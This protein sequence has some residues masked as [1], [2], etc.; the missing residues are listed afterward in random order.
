VL[1]LGDHPARAA[2]AVERAPREVG[3]AADGTALSQTRQRHRGEIVGDGA[4]QALVARQAEDVIDAVRLAPGH[5]LVAGKAR[6]GTQQDL[7][8]RP[9][10]ADLADDASHFILGAGGRVDVRAPE[11]GREQVPATEHVQRQIA[12]A[13]VIAM[14][15]AALLMP[16]QRVIRGV[17]VENDFLGWRLVRFEEE[18]DKQ[19]LDR[20]RIMADLVITARR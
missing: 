5:E 4:N 16:V 3:E 10:G 17:E 12:V 18:L 15:E 7:H 20:C 14:E 11:L 1:S 13:V 8:P 19:M 2:P 9:T 6:I